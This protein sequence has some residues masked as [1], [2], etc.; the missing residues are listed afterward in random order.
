MMNIKFAFGILSLGVLLSGCHDAGNKAMDVEFTKIEASE[1]KESSF[2]ETSHDFNLSEFQL[3][4]MI[5]I[6]KEAKATGETNVGFL[7]KSNK[8]ISEETQEIVK[9]NIRNVMYKQGFIDSRIIDLGTVI[10]DSAR[11]GIRVDILKYNV[12]PINTAPWD[13]EIG[14]ADV[15]KNLPRYGSSIAYNL[16]EMVAN[17]A[18]LVRARKYKGQSTNDSISALSTTASSSSSSSSSSK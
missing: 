11:T 12:K 5:K 3:N 8:Y 13:T 9:K 2:F 18:D 15:Y 1:E 10:Y 6:L 7:L 16:N 17:K 14:D 4:Q